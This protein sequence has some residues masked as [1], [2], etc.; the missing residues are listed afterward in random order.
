M[1]LFTKK[2]C[3][4]AITAAIV[5][6]GCS[7]KPKRPDPSATVL[8][9]NG[10]AINP[11]DVSMTDSGL[12][13]G[14]GLGAMNSSLNP[15]GQDRTA[16]QA[17]YFDFDKSGI[18]GSERSKLDDAKKYLGEHPEFR[19]LLEGHCDWRGTS[20]YNLGLG[21]RRANEAKKYLL[22]LGVSADKIETLSKGSL[23]AVEKADDAT[24]AK[25]RRVELVVLTK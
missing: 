2:L 19:L 11:G 7:K 5:L 8:G 15:D 3:F 23:D 9:P 1:N 14:T 13:P 4:V 24:M 21:D 25:D 6:T 17:V 18:K 10:N 16:L 20:E 22:T 12:A